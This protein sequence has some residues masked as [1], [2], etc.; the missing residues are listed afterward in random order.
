MQS[1]SKQRLPHIDE[2]SVEIAASPE[3]VWEALSRVVEASFGS[4]ATGRVARLLGCAD[5]N[6][7]G[8][9]PLATGSAF[10]GFHVEAAKRP[11]ELALDAGDPQPRPRPRDPPHTRRRQA[12]RRAL[13]RRIRV[14]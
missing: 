6:A 10:P 5:V 3:A 9:R 14:L 4:A 2:H 11:H 7:S 12:A 1:P 8:P 13:T